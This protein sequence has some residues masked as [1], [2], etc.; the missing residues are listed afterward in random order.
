MTPQEQGIGWVIQKGLS[1]NDRNTPEEV[2]EWAISLGK[3]LG[4]SESRV[5]KIFA[6][7]REGKLKF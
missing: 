2:L 6:D 5:R 4:V 7:V 3:D 1:T